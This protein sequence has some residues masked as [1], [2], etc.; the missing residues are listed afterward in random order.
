M[1]TD[2]YLIRAV[3]YFVLLIVLIVVLYALQYYF[4]KTPMSIEE[5]IAMLQGDARSK[6]IL[7]VFAVLALAYPSFG[8]M[9]R[10]L[11]ISLAANRAGIDTAMSS[12]GFAQAGERDGVLLYRATSAA[13]RVRMLWE[14]ELE[15]W[16]EGDR[17][18]IRGHRAAVVQ[19]IYRSEIYMRKENGE[20]L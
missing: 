9:T 5:Y 10:S 18:V 12:C 16:S 15:V 2:R 8:Y 6:W 19:V 14:D 4:E 20:E 11:P 1:R 3:K 13:R 7:P 17:T